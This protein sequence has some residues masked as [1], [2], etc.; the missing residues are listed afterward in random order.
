[1]HSGLQNK[2]RKNSAP[3]SSQNPAVE[4]ELGSSSSKETHDDVVTAGSKQWMSH[5][6]RYEFVQSRAYSPVKPSQLQTSE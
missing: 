3:E 5:R 2:G 4:S 1:M 6:E